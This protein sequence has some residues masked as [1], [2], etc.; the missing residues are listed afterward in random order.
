VSKYGLDL[1]DWGVNQNL[2]NV[3]SAELGQK[4]RNKMSSNLKIRPAVR[5]ASVLGCW[6][7]N[8]RTQ[9]MT[10]KASFNG[11]TCYIRYEN[12]KQPIISDMKM[13]KTPVILNMKM[14]KQLWKS[15]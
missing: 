1:R 3:L 15:A 12:A 10:W 11:C 5:L 8:S 14:Q 9:K 2:D 13:Q 4:P 7:I 6:K